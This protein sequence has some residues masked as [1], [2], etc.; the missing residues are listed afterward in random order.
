MIRALVDT[1]AGPSVITNELRKE[2]NIPITK[3]SNVVLTIAN[4]KSIASLGRAEIKIE[5]DENL[6]IPLEFEVID[7]KR[8]DLILGTDL[9]KYGIINM[10]EGLLTI[11]LDNE[12]YEIPIDFKGKKSVKFDESESESDGDSENMENVN[13]DSSEESE[14]EN[15]YEDNEKEELLTTMEEVQKKKKNNVK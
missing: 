13:D 9:L 3:K 6:E 2:L 12:I 5:I 4:G 10:K 11:E 7:S 8:K 14:S 15:E 1:G